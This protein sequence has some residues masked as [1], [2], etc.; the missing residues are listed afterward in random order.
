MAT[1]KT[2]KTRRYVAHG[3]VGRTE[4]DD[5]ALVNHSYGITATGYGRPGGHPPAPFTGW[6]YFPLCHPLDEDVKFDVDEIEISWA[7]GKRVEVKEVKVYDGPIEVHSFEGGLP[8]HS[9]HHDSPGT[10]TLRMPHEGHRKPIKHALCVSMRISISQSGE[11][12]EGWASFYS[13][14]VVLRK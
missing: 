11:A 6:I 3:A 12:S 4:S 13:V 14:A 1:E 8:D 10:S 9:G 2:E 5:I 7:R